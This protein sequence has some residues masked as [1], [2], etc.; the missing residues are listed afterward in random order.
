MKNTSKD[1]LIFII[2]MMLVLIASDIERYKELDLL[3]VLY[4]FLKV[5][6]G[7]AISA[8]IIKIKKN[9]S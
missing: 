7:T 2:L 1:L 4:L 3:Q 6:V 5:M 9:T 8:F